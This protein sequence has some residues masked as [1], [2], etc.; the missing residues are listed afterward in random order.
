MADRPPTRIAE[1]FKLG[2]IIKSTSMTTVYLAT[3]PGR[4]GAVIVKIL[5]V[6]PATTTDAERSRFQQA[7]TAVATLRLPGFPSVVESGWTSPAEGYVVMAPAGYRPIGDVPGVT[8]QR[9][10]AWLAKSARALDALH[11]A[12][13]AHLNVRLDN[14]AVTG[15]PEDEGVVLFGLGTGWLRRP[16]ADDPFTA[17]E[18]AADEVS[19]DEWRCDV[20]SLARTACALLGLSAVSAGREH[21]AVGLP[22]KVRAALADPEALRTV[23]ERSLARRPADRPSSMSE[24]ARELDRSVGVAAGQGRS[25]GQTQPVDVPVAAE[26][27]EADVAEAPEDEGLERTLKLDEQTVA[28]LRAARAGAGSPGFVRP[29]PRTPDERPAPPA[30]GGTQAADGESPP[31]RASA[32]D[33]TPTTRERSVDAPTPPSSPRRESVERE[34]P[35]P[36]RSAAAAPPAERPE[37]ASTDGSAAP[38]APTAEPRRPGPSVSYLRHPWLWAAGSVGLVV[39]ATLVGLAWHMAAQRAASLR[40]T[41]PAV[42]ATVPPPTEPPALPQK[43]L[44]DELEAL[45]AAGEVAQA[46]ARLAAVPPDEIARLSEVDRQRIATIRQTIADR[47]RWDLVRAVDAALAS[48]D[49]ARLERAVG[50]LT[51]AGPI[52]AAAQ[53][54]AELERKLAAARTLVDLNHRLESAVEQRRWGD[55]LDL[56]KTILAAVPTCRA[57]S[58]DRDKAATALEV[59]A[60]SLT[61]NGKLADAQ[62]TLATIQRAW[63]ER[64]GL[65]DRMAAVTARIEAEQRVRNVIAAAEAAGRQGRPDTGL[66]DLAQLRPDH[67]LASQV[68]SARTALAAQL[69]QLD[70]GTPRLTIAGSSKLDYDKNKT[71]VVELVVEDDFEVETVGFFARR[72]GNASFVQFAAVDQGAGHYT[73]SIPAAFHQNQTVEFYALAR[74]PSGHTGELGSPTAPLEIKRH[75]WGWFGR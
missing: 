68:D 47:H 25:P 4:E 53:D 21:P 44:A 46:E 56:A 11:L 70:R 13:T 48:G 27:G 8:P 28:E 69:A 60:D 75:R 26:T 51:T 16:A 59:E 61:M 54:S 17:P 40:T 38:M 37:V 36:L 33:A 15:T 71:A 45:V 39:V 67:P 74:D 57:V 66:E 55:V 31:A 35:P 52:A 20:F 64:E 34:L 32:R 2:R 42:A 10:V 9:I 19:T 3:E 63:P 22:D 1:R 24:V 14:I 30:G 49:L 5:G 23:I 12:G 7:V 65:A 43:S 50:A 6:E 73:V 18:L 29:A 62:S 58:D 41:A 72:R